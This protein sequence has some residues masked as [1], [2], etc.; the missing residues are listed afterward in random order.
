MFERIPK[1]K[2]RPP[3]VVAVCVPAPSNVS[4]GL[5]EGPD[6]RRP[7]ISQG[8]FF[9]SAL[10]TLPDESRVASPLASPG[11]GK[12]L[13]PAFGKLPLLH[14]IDA[15]R[16]FRVPGFVFPELF[17]PGLRA[18]RGPAADSLLKALMRSPS[19]NEELGSLGPAIGCAWWREFP[20]RPA[21]RPWRFP[22]VLLSWE[23][24]ADVAV[25]DDQRRRVVR[26]RK[27]VGL[28]ELLQIV[29]VAHLGGRF[30]PLRLKSHP[31]VFR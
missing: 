16:P 4:S 18:P 14:P 15:D 31:H 1:C 3:G 21:V 23:L 13:V 11:I 27:N 30:Q 22:R 6:R 25:R 28:V 29:G 9:A 12:V 5:V 24:Q 7:P 20:L 17:E 2:L 26:S 10:S 19:G 8:T